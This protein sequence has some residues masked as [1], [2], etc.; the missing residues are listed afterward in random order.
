MAWTDVSKRT[1]IWSF[2]TTKKGWGS[3]PW[4]SQWG[5]GIQTSWSDVSKQSSSYT[6][7][8]KDTATYTPVS[9][10]TTVWT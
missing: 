1:S 3:Q 9:K 7:V 8:S 6:P 5:D 2:L 10:A 4:G